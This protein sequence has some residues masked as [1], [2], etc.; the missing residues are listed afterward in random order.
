[1]REL[2]RLIFVVSNSQND[3]TDYQAE[4]GIDY[5]VPMDDVAA[6]CDACDR[7]F[8][9]RCE[10]LFATYDGRTAGVVDRSDLSVFRLTPDASEWAGDH[11]QWQA[12]WT[13]YFGEHAALPAARREV[14]A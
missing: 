1:M 13:R 6:L 11:A 8:G 5:V 4:V 2:E 14:P 3:L 9:R 7:Y 12:I 10:Y